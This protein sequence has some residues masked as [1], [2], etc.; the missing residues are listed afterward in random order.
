MEGD[1][2]LLWDA[3]VM[4]FEVV[5]VGRDAGIDRVGEVILS[6]P[7]TQVGVEMGAA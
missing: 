5:R 1:E 7:R 6:R 4:V 2:L 3:F